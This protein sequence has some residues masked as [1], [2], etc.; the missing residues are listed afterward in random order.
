MEGSLKTC[1][2]DVWYDTEAPGVGSNLILSY[3]VQESEQ[4][5]AYIALGVLPLRIYG[6]SHTYQHLVEF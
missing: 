4:H 6:F 5:P 3:P 2:C 1:L